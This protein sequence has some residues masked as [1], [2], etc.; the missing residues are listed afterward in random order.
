VP[1]EIEADQINEYLFYLQQNFSPSAS[2]FKFAIYSLRFAYRMDGIPEKCVALPSIKKDKKLPVVL[3]RD[4]IKRLFAVTTCLKHRVLIALLYGCGLRCFEA[5]HVR[6]EDLD[7]DRKMLHVREGKGKK[8]RY[9][10][11]STVLI[12]WI[13]EY[14]STDNPQV[15]LFNGRRKNLPDSVVDMHYSPKGLGWVIRQAVKKAGIIKRVSAHTLR[16]TFATHLLEDGLDIVSIRDLLGHS[17]IET[18]MVYLHVAHYD[19]VKSFSPLDTIYGLRKHT[20]MIGTV[21]GLCML[22]EHLKECRD[23][24]EVVV[25]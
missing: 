18:T 10:P 11:L 21:N 15:W 9:V 19:R 17:S 13:R 1:T 23:C 4:E 6:L 5:R 14:L 3:N 25:E 7:F 12:E 24:R 8:E 22:A 2:F 16:H 20:P